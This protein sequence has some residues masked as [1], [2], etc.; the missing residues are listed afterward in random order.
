MRLPLVRS[1]VVVA[2]VPVPRLSH[3]T[4]LAVLFLPTTHGPGSCC[5]AS[6]WYRNAQQPL[7]YNELGG[8]EP[9][10]ALQL[11][12]VCFAK[13]R[14]SPNW[15]WSSA[16]TQERNTYYSSTAT[17]VIRH[18]RRTYTHVHVHGIRMGQCMPDDDAPI[19]RRIRNSDRSIDHGSSAEMGEQTI[20]VGQLAN[21]YIF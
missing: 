14:V 5:S 15:W 8:L 11:L 3:H 4:L 12:S 2:S 9:Y 20:W 16:R 6:T 1:T 13:S 17:A 10:P 19:S 7:K 21:D 18:A